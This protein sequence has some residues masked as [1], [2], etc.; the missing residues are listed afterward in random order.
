MKDTLLDLVAHTLPV[1]IETIKYV[2]EKNTVKFEGVTDD[3]TCVLFG[4]THKDVSGFD[5]TFGIPNLSK[6]SA[7]LKLEPYQEGA[8][9]KLE[10]KPDNTPSNVHFEDAKGQFK[11]DHRFMS[12]A[13]I[14]E[15]MNEI[16]WKMT[17]NYVVDVVP[18]EEAIQRFGWQASISDEEVFAVKTDGTDL[19]FMF[20]DQSSHAGEFVFA[21]NVK[22]K[23]SGNCLW[24]VDKVLPTLKLMGDVSMSFDD[25]G[26]LRVTVDSGLA[27]F[28]YM[29]MATTR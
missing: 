24:F 20:G 1:G 29:L 11:N 5:G 23:M 28:E 22:G 19:K 4:E 15:K 25:R 12:T 6:L 7:L 26:I 2:C 27:K 17:P 18:T 16:K 13:D 14:T 10:T 21:E 8:T 3:R 9:I